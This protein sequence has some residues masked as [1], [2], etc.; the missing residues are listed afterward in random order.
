M[1]GEQ[2]EGDGTTEIVSRAQSALASKPAADD[3]VAQLTAATRTCWYWLHPCS[4][5][6]ADLI[7]WTIA[8]LAA[9]VLR[10]AFGGDLP[11]EWYLRSMPVLILTP[12]PIFWLQGLYAPVPSSAPDE[13]GR[14]VRANL[15]S[16]AFLA[17]AAF[18]LQ[19]GEAYSRLAFAAGFVL[20]LVLTPLVRTM[21][22]RLFSGSSRWYRPCVII[23]DGEVAEG[24]LRTFATERRLGLRAVAV[25]AGEAGGQGPG[26]LPVLARYDQSGDLIRRSGLR[27]AVVADP[28][29]DRDEYRTLT[30]SL[31]GAA[32]HLIVIPSMLGMSSLW[33]MAHDLGGMLGLEVR[34]Q[35]LRPW[36]ALQ[37]RALDVVI[38]L[39]ILIGCSW[40]YLL[41]MLAIKLTSRGP[42]FYCQ[43]RMGRGGRTI[44]MWKFRSMVLDAEERLQALLDRDPAAREEW[45]RVAK[46]K[47]DPRVTPIGR[48]M[49]ITSLDEIPQFWNILKGEMSVVGPR[50]LALP[51]VKKYASYGV[52][53]HYYSRM[54]PGLTGMWQVS[55]RSNTTYEQRVAYDMYY[56]RNWS[57]WLD[58]VLVARTV[59][60]VLAREGA[61]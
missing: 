12:I 41:L 59:K 10:Q 18:L 53:Y 6:I 21:V 61:Y 39:A 38:S 54:M 20:S 44:R 11:L 52:P 51:E 23:G 19:F 3:A 4:L 5:V 28:D 40:L 35:L 30:E 25:I 29:M 27:Y 50:P 48:F 24:A 55:G 8:I 16:F 13:L 15:L 14:L 34:N 49:R 2:A 56:A 33:V 57:I 36:S 42:I 9:V 1:S 31:E 45:S 7:S 46:L 26:G 43:K 32:P 60:V 17:M 58:L 37:K 22:R 47:N